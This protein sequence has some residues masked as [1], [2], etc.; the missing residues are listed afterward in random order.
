MAAVGVVDFGIGLFSECETFV[1]LQNEITCDR[2]NFFG[3]L[4]SDR[5]LKFVNPTLVFLKEFFNLFE[6]G[7]D[8]SC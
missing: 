4:C 3:F 8:P 2:A 1:K 6:L 5:R 7:I